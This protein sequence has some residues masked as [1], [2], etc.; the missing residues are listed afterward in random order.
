MHSLGVAGESSGRVNTR[1]KVKIAP[2][3]V[4]LPSSMWGWVNPVWR[5]DREISIHFSNYWGFRVLG[6]WPI[7]MSIYDSEEPRRQGHCN[8]NHPWS[9]SRI[10]SMRSLREAFWSPSRA[11]IAAAIGCQRRWSAYFSMALTAGARQDGLCPCPSIAISAFSSDLWIF[12]WVRRTQS[13]KLM[14]AVAAV[15]SHGLFCNVFQ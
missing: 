14:Q 7:A 10:W 8:G 15:T 5:H 2:D 3:V 9:L 11:R 4:C 13:T 12:G 1:V 6:C